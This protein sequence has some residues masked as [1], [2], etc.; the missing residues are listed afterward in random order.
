MGELLTTA[1]PAASAAATTTAA[2]VGSARGGDTESADSTLDVGDAAAALASLPSSAA[3][4][5]ASSVDVS[6]DEKL[7]ALQ[8][9]EALI[10]E[11]RIVE[12]SSVTSEELA[13]SAEA[14]AEAEAAAK[15]AEADAQGVPWTQI[16]DP[17]LPDK[18]KKDKV[19]PAPEA[20]PQHPKPSHAMTHPALLLGLALLLWLGTPRP[21][22]ARRHGPC[23]STCT[24]H[25]SSPRPSPREY[26]HLLP[27]HPP[28][29]SPPPPRLPLVAT[30]GEAEEPGCTGG[31][32]EEGQEG[33]ALALPRAGGR[34]RRGRR[35]HGRR[36]AGEEGAF[37]D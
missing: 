20:V 23:P 37:G 6:D 9:E 13:D 15:L 5:S 26:A 28:P 29:P 32:R 3:L 22:S 1:S 30:E 36:L 4:G 17:T 24:P 33:E 34:D 8:R 19:G 16:M 18:A 25:G 31:G 12:E 14:S 11:E 27:P 7:L 10:E 35:A 21:T 2:T